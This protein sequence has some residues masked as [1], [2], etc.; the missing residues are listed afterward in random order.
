[1]NIFTDKKFIINLKRRPDRKAHILE[2]MEKHGMSNY[3]IFEA[4]DANDIEET[5]VSKTA[6]KWTKE[7]LACLRSHLAVIK[8]AKE[9]NLDYVTILEDD[10][11][12]VDNFKEQYEKVVSQLTVFSGMFY[13]CANHAVKPNK[14]KGSE[15]IGVCQYAQSLVC[16]VISKHYYDII[17]HELSKEDKPID[18]I[19]IS[20][21]HSTDWSKG[22]ALVAFCAIP[23]L[24]YQLAGYS[25]I[26][27][28][29]TDY[30]QHFSN[31]KFSD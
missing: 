10:C 18:E 23:N 21:I 11:V 22:N 9:S 19:F 30:A 17:I 16:Y 1:M 7:Q 5:L 24:C 28:K 25:D 3:E 29:E 14:I 20:R 8:K 15:N 12:F 13:L 2:Q 27:L 26:E 6:D 4:I 31:S